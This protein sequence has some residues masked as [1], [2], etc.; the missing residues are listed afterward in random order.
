MKTKRIKLHVL[1]ASAIACSSF[2]LI[3]QAP[4]PKDGFV[5]NEHTA[6]EIGKAVLEPMIGKDGVKKQE[7][8]R[9]ELRGGVWEVRG[10]T[11]LK[12]EVRGGGGIEMRIDKQTGQIIGYYFSR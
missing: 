7:P 11:D 3:A 2:A 4:P 10:R 5:P 8:F 12:A 6:I 9:A 1:I